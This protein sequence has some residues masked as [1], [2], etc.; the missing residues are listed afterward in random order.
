MTP[1]AYVPTDRSTVRRQP[2]RAAYDAAT[3]HGVLDE[4]WVAH[5]G[6]VADGAP[7]VIP[8]AHWRVGGTL[9]LHGAPAGR[10]M[11]TLREGTPICVTV[12]LIDGLVLARSGFHHSMNYRSVVLF[13]RPE[14][15]SDE[16]AKRAALD[17]FVE[18]IEPGR[19]A[20][21]RP[22]SPAELAGTLLVALPLAEASAK[23]RTGPPQDDE[24]D[25]AWPVWA[26]VIP[27]ALVAGER[28]PDG[29][30]ASAT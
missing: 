24:G 13:G 22:P 25:L 10:L 7:V 20:A 6:F 26:G 27:L 5:V 4:A 18:R 9:Y 2:A 19:A 17:A 29:P 23:V 1:H 30:T 8:M 21:V 16:A 11:R 28:I 14:V 12:T 3:V 15:V